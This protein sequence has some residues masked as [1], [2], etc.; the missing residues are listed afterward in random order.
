MATGSRDACT[1]D[2]CRS[3]FYECPDVGSHNAAAG[4]VT[5]SYHDCTCS[6]CKQGECA[7]GLKEYTFFA[8]SALKCNPSQCSAN[9]YGCPDAGSHNTG[10]PGT[11]SEALVFASYNDCMCSCCKE[12]GAFTRPH[13]GST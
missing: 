2:M 9:F 11:T 13:F 5:A 8:E 6:C 3:K 12:A 1:E 4:S 7:A 10:D